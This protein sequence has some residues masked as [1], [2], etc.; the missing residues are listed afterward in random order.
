MKLNLDIPILLY[1]HVVAEGPAD[2]E[3]YEVSLSQFGRQLDMIRKAGFTTVSLQR[4]FRVLRG[5]EPVPPRMLVIT[6]DDAYRS[7]RELVLP[8]LLERQMAATVFVP[9]GLGDINRWDQERG[10]PERQIMC[11]DE[12]R[13][14]AASGMEVGAHGWVHRNLKQCSEAE[15]REEIFRSREEMARC[16]GAPPEFFA[17]PYG[18]YKPESFALLEEAGYAGA[19]SVSSDEPAVTANRFAMRRVYIHPGDG[20]LRFRLKL[21]RWYLRRAARWALNL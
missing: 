18:G 12:I 6:F 17:Y 1:H 2:P 8:V 15:A 5:E 13:Q 20:L 14:I 16:L 19:V 10:F 7:F 9:A 3:L 21:S 4:L 11:A